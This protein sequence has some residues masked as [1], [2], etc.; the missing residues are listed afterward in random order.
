MSINFNDIISSNNDAR[1]YALTGMQ[2]SVILQSL[3]ANYAAAY[4]YS[5]GVK[6]TKEDADIALKIYSDTNDAI[7]TP[8]IGMIIAAPVQLTGFLVCDGASYPAADYPVLAEMFGGGVTFTVPD[9]R[10]RFVLGSSLSNPVNSTGGESTHTL[11]EDEIPAHTHTTIPHTHAE[12]GAVPSV[13]L[14]GAG[15]PVPSAVPAASV[16]AAAS[17]TINSTGGNQPHNNM[18]PYYSLMYLISAG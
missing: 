16:T 8:I 9:L 12:S 7:M 14:E 2:L 13:S 10:D 15:V 18:P 11:I 5:T 6:L 4:T 17:V 1:L 3:N